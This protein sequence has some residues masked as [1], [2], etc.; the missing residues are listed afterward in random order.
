M[1]SS[2]CFT[3]AFYSFESTVSPTATGNSQFLFSCCDCLAC[4]PSSL[5]MGTGS[6]EG[7]G[8]MALQF[9]WFLANPEFARGGCWRR[10]WALWHQ[11]INGDKLVFRLL[12]QR[13][14][15]DMLYSHTWPLPRHKRGDHETQVCSTGDALVCGRFRGRGP[16]TQ[17]GWARNSRWNKSHMT[18]LI[19]SLTQEQH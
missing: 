16:E 3:G 17:E 18:A 2:S 14:D 1:S 4:S 5:H 19:G 11:N 8:F 7:Q 10:I 13:H 12:W 9:P 15:Q 6:K